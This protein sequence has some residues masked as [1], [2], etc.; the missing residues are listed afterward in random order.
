MFF[1]KEPAYVKALLTQL[2]DGGWGCLDNLHAAGDADR[3]YGNLLDYGLP[4]PSLWYLL[5]V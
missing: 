4:A 3:V 5:A 1:F 2:R